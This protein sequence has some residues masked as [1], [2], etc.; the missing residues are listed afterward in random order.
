MKRWLYDNLGEILAAAVAAIGA[1]V[2]AIITV[3]ITKAKKPGRKPK[4]G[5][6]EKHGVAIQKV[7]EDIIRDP[8]KEVIL[9]KTKTWMLTFLSL[10][11]LLGALAVFIIRTDPPF[12]AYPSQVYTTTTYVAKTE[13]LLPTAPLSPM[14]IFSPAWTNG[15]RGGIERWEDTDIAIGYDNRSD[16]DEIDPDYSI[17]VRLYDEIGSIIYVPE[18]RYRSFK[19]KIVIPSDGRDEKLTYVIEIYCDDALAFESMPINRRNPSQDFDINI[20]DA[21]VVKIVIQGGRP[22]VGY[23]VGLA[24]C[25]FSRG[26]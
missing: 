24:N 5:R 6:K 3:K 16:S 20:A 12:A 4:P 14:D 23:A 15:T 9:K 11:V 2:A 25:S 13:S 19:G 18:Q 7:E 1:I 8:D 17:K 22:W 21:D 10:G 26:R